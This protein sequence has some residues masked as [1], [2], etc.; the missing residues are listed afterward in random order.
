MEFE[1]PL[2]DVGDDLG[3]YSLVARRR[4]LLRLARSSSLEALSYPSC[5]CLCRGVPDS[6]V[7]Q[8]VGGE[9]SLSLG[10]RSSSG[11]VIAVDLGKHEE[12]GKGG[13]GKANSDAQNKE[14]DKIGAASCLLIGECADCSDDTST[15][16][17]RN[18][19]S[20]YAGEHELAKEN[21]E[22]QHEVEAGVVAEGLVGGSE[23]E[24]KERGMKKKP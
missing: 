14:A 21:E 3:N 20:H 19:K 8:N 7:A 10:Q 1:L 18:T 5:C 6:L 4:L 13:N 12:V 9:L 24:R 2:F 17:A 15:S 16:G 22:E 11:A 23:P